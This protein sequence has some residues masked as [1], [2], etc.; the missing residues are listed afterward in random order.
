M[1]EITFK[2]PLKPQTKE[3][4]RHGR[5]GQ[6]YT[7]K[8]TRA[9]EEAVKMFAMA[10]MRG[11]SKLTGPIEIEIL[12]IYRWPKSWSEKKRK[13]NGCFKTS[14]PDVDNLLKSICDPLNG[15]L[16]SDDRLVCKAIG[17]KQWGFRESILIQARE[18]VWQ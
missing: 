15:V 2:I 14:A 4:A 17:F 1:K 12:F 9:Y 13:E 16:W 5:G 7:P 6:V 11:K 8:K 18:M 3:R 10:E